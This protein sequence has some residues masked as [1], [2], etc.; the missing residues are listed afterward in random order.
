MPIYLTPRLEI[1]DILQL[2]AMALPN[3]LNPDF[4]RNLEGGPGGGG[5]RVLT[6]PSYRVLPSVRGPRPYSSPFTNPVT[7]PPA[8][9][10]QYPDGRNYLYSR[11]IGTLNG[12]GAA[13][14][15]YQPNEPRIW[16]SIGSASLQSY[17]EAAF[18]R[19]EI[20]GMADLLGNAVPYRAPVPRS[21]TVSPV[22]FFYELMRMEQIA[23]TY[24]PLVITNPSNMIGFPRPV[25][26]TFPAQ[27]F[28]SQVRWVPGLYDFGTQ[29]WDYAYSL[30]RRLR[31]IGLGRSSD[32]VAL[33]EAQYRHSL[34]GGKYKDGA[35][36]YDDRGY[37]FA[38]EQATFRVESPSKS[39]E[40]LRQL[41]LNEPNMWEKYGSII[42][43]EWASD[44]N[45]T[46]LKML[47]VEQVRDEWRMKREN[48][49]KDPPAKANDRKIRSILGHALAVYNRVDEAAEYVEGIAQAV[50]M[51]WEDPRLGP[52]EGTLKEAWAAFV[53]AAM[54]DGLGNAIR[55][56]GGTAAVV[57]LNPFRIAYN[58]LWNMAENRLYGI[59]PSLARGPAGE[60]NQAMGILHN[61][62]VGPGGIE[63]HVSGE[64]NEAINAYK[65]H[66]DKLF[67]TVQQYAPWWM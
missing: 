4:L 12:L 17:T 20:G 3:P 63:G 60:F 31:R 50:I 58:V 29:A 54:N 35:Y 13:L 66:Q 25:E 51:S 2:A 40:D 19:I 16:P 61:W 22:G 39:Y 34:Y 26:L 42:T 24:V 44:A 8:T 37:L 65:G 48:R 18:P 7:R 1:Q 10:Y 27:A 41:E 11:F 14:T 45:Y 64:L 47:R 28:A 56:F 21:S 43:K 52:R 33:E 9:M 59:V 49:P 23:G 6:F 57:D 36:Y 53:Y 62:G 46:G 30:S 32:G 15:P 67:R 38:N 5:G 55:Q